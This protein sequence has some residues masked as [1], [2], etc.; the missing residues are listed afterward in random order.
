MLTNRK[1]EMLRTKIN[2]VLNNE[3]KWKIGEVKFL[4]NGVVNAVFLI[5]EENLGALVVRT[6]WRVNENLIDQNSDGIVSL[7]KE[8]T[9][10]R[11]CEKHK[12]PVPKIHKLYLSNDINFLVSD[13]IIG[14]EKE[15][16]SYDIGHLTAKIHKVPLDDLTIIDQN[17]RPLSNI[18]ANRIIERVSSLSAIIDS[19]IIIPSSEELETI[20]NTSQIKNSLL[21]LDVRPPNLIAKE[22]KIK[23]IID[24]DNAFIGNP[25]MEL[26]RISESKEL[27]EREFIKGYNNKDII[28]N[29]DIVIQSIYRL[30]T[31]LM[32]SILF[33]SILNDANKAEYYLK[34]VHVLSQE[35][36][37]KF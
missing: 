23:A 30:D 19:K 17:E 15:I 5:N 8:Y 26:M 16:S 24:W 31:A 27:N 2:N 12:I 21:H 25:M 6:P 36:V 20:L 34:R 7:K 14:D 32:L 22:G 33:K 9:I 10:S 13:F 1:I 3:L 28:D 18:I 29:T 37:R 4:G 11:H 35:I